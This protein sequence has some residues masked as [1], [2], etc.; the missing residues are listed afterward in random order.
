MPKNSVSAQLKVIYRYENEMS[1][2]PFDAVQH[3]PMEV[4]SED[5]SRD[6][7]SRQLETG[8]TVHQDKMNLNSDSADSAISPKDIKTQNDPTPN[9]DRNGDDSK[10]KIDDK[11]ISFS[12]QSILDHGDTTKDAKST[13]SKGNSAI[14]IVEEG[15]AT[16]IDKISEDMTNCNTY[17]ISSGIVRYSKS[18][19][20]SYSI[21]VGSIAEYDSDFKK[22]VSNSECVLFNKAKTNA[23]QANTEKTAKTPAPVH[24]GLEAAAAAAA[25]SISANTRRQ[26]TTINLDADTVAHKET[27][28]RN[29]NAGTAPQNEIIEEQDENQARAT[30]DDRIGID[31]HPT[32]IIHYPPPSWRGGQRPMTIKPHTHTKTQLTTRPKPPQQLVPPLTPPPPPLMTLKLPEICKEKDAPPQLPPPHLWYRQP[33][34]TVLTLNQEQNIVSHKILNNTAGHTVS[35]AIINN[36][37]AGKNQKLNKNSAQQKNSSAYK[38]KAAQQQPERTLT[39]PPLPPLLQH[40]GI[41]AQMENNIGAAGTEQEH[42]ADAEATHAT[43]DR[44]DQRAS[45]HH[46]ASL[47][48]HGT[49]PSQMGTDMLSQTKQHP[50]W[51]TSAPTYLTPPPPLLSLKIQPTYV[52][53]STP[54]RLSLLQPE[55]ARLPTIRPIPRYPTRLWRPLQPQNLKPNITP[56]PN[57]LLPFIPLHQHDGPHHIARKNASWDINPVTS[58]QMATNSNELNKTEKAIQQKNI[59]QASHINRSAMQQELGIDES[60]TRSLSRQNAKNKKDGENSTILRNNQDTH[61]AN[62][63]FKRTNQYSSIELD[64]AKALLTKEYSGLQRKKLTDMLLNAKTTIT[65]YLDYFGE[66]EKVAPLFLPGYIVNTPGCYALY[67]CK[68]CNKEIM[69]RHNFKYHQ[70]TSSHLNNSKD[71][72]KTLMQN[73]YEDRIQGQTRKIPKEM[74]NKLKE[75]VVKHL[76]ILYMTKAKMSIKCGEQLDFFE[77]QVESESM[78]LVGPEQKELPLMID[79]PRQSNEQDYMAWT[80][81]SQAIRHRCPPKFSLFKVK[82]LKLISDMYLDRH[83]SRLQIQFSALFYKSLSYEAEQPQR[84]WII[85]MF[86]KMTTRPNAWRVIKSNIN[87]NNLTFALKTKAQALEVKRVS[88]MAR[89]LFHIVLDCPFV[90]MAYISLL[91]VLMTTEDIQEFEAS[92]VCLNNGIIIDIFL[93]EGAVT[94]QSNIDQTEI[95]YP[96]QEVQQMNNG[97]HETDQM[98]ETTEHGNR[99]G[100]TWQDDS[101]ILVAEP[102]PTTFLPSVGQHI[103]DEEWLN[104]TRIQDDIRMNNVKKDKKVSKDRN[105]IDFTQDYAEIMNESNICASSSLYSSNSSI[106]TIPNDEGQE[107]IGDND[108]AMEIDKEVEEDQEKMEQETEITLLPDLDTTIYVPD[109]PIDTTEVDLMKSFRQFGPIQSINIQIL[110]DSKNAS[111]RFTNY[112]KAKSAM[113]SMNGTMYK[114]KVCKIF[115]SKRRSFPEPKDLYTNSPLERLGKMVQNMPQSIEHGTTSHTEMETDIPENIGKEGATSKKNYKRKFKAHT[116]LEQNSTKAA[117]PSKESVISVDKTQQLTDSQ[118]EVEAQNEASNQ[119]DTQDIALQLFQHWEQNL[120]FHEDIHKTKNGA[121]ITKITNELA[122]VAGKATPYQKEKI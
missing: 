39:M 84:H 12:I 63:S 27:T 26:D 88:S 18:P 86:E 93:K 13:T 120:N 102:P 10:G 76:H 68:S 122:N 6:T 96:E 111:I 95:V 29:D 35:A 22:K 109:L 64:S 73:N 90:P 33:P 11:N 2:E 40:Y 51:L 9:A 60:N 98:N 115:M 72:I 45:N 46:N 54:A 28:E 81:T 43:Q 17:Q 105:T 87:R 52:P 53:T 56:P 48:P 36:G 113:S 44:S 31:H 19:I 92:S 119:P 21:R 62:T 47:P 3:P 110:P 23:Q 100:Q 4:D 65:P 7:S 38:R 101:N 24:P 79:L 89:W 42:R 55:P 1:G 85:E 121:F 94:L 5:A 74:V 118:S 71:W 116:N 66:P 80:R 117:R 70:Q 61:K 15:R 16:N 99:E 77:D 107:T 112:F 67:I 91:A 37:A 104:Q 83:E 8:N 114:N 103:E 75:A 57:R 78:D 41:R 49:Y 58:H 32:T 20:A 82:L 34:P 50:L 69:S 97:Q 108:E 59:V 30:K 14:N 25:I 106:Q